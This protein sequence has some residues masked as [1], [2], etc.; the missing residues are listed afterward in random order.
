M[1]AY[2]WDEIQPLCVYRAKVERYVDT[3]DKELI[4]DPA[5]RRSQYYTRFVNGL[6]EDYAEFVNLSIP[7]KCQDINKALEACLRFQSA[8]K[9]NTTTKPAFGLC[10]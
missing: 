6:P 3:F 8:K 2:I 5:G 1:K 9:R 10:L 7:A 4:S